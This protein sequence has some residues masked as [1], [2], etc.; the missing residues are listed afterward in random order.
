MLLFAGASLRSVVW[1]AAWRCAAEGGSRMQFRGKAI[2]PA[3][4]NAFPHDS[5]LHSPLHHFRSSTSFTLF[6]D[7]SHH[8]GGLRSCFPHRVAVSPYSDGCQSRLLSHRRIRLS[9]RL[10]KAATSRFGLRPSAAFSSTGISHRPQ[11]TTRARVPSYPRSVFLQDDRVQR[12]S[13]LLYD[14]CLFASPCLGAWSSS[15]PSC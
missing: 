8:H 4:S 10:H 3:I 12:A 9:L 5:R 13:S 6:T 11:A 7:D 1:L 2:G 14:A 15:S